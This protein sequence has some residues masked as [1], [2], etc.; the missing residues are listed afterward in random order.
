MWNIVDQAYDGM[1]KHNGSVLLTFDESI[2]LKHH[3]KTMKQMLKEKQKQDPVTWK[4]EFLN[5]RVKDSL[6]SYF[7]YMMLMNRQVLKHVFY[8]STFL[9]LNLQEETNT[10]FQSKK[11]KYE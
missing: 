11:M 7:T 5:L 4:I 8:L 10:Q 9:M 2:T 3:L 6:S 1:Q